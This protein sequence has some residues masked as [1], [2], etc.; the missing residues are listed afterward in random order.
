M[1]KYTV[2]LLDADQT[3]L[4]FSAAEGFAIE[5]TCE[6]F[7]ISFSGAV[8]QRYSEINLA[9]WK[10][11]EKGLVTRDEVK[12][13]RFEEFAKEMGCAADPAAMGR[14]Y[15]TT[16]A[17]CGFILKGADRVCEAL[18]KKYR[19]Y[20]VTNGLLHVQKSRLALSGLL[21]YFS[22]CF[23]SEETGYAKP[24]KRFF[25]FV[26]DKIGIDRSEALIVGDSLSS[27]I[28]GGVNAGIDTCL[29]GEAEE[30]CA[31]SP[32]YRAKNFEELL[33]LFL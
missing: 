27:D 26:L 5:K 28:Q 15:E 3:L 4:D 18:S 11:L 16:L 19:L 2:L 31:P 13:R 32:T 25:D 1:K 8:A 21:T 24:D 30:D 23:I 20:I 33:S 9:L 29:F 22:G 17:N 12:L 10:K 7:G 6:K 14:F